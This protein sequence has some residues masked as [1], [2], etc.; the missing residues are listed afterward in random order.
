MGEAKGGPD[1]LVIDL[2]DETV[3]KARSVA[4]IVSVISQDEEA[5]RV[6]IFL[7][8]SAVDA[9]ETWQQ[10]RQVE[11][12]AVLSYSAVIDTLNPDQVHSVDQI[13][14]ALLSDLEQRFETLPQLVD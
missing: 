14:T 10:D 6:Q 4:E 1:K 13:S 8:Q 11:I 5:S 12:A 3:R 9:I 7:D 2:R